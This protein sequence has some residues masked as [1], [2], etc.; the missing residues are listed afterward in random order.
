P[1]GNLNGVSGPSACGALGYA[2]A[3]SEYADVVVAVTDHLEEYPLVPVEI[4]QSRV[5]YVVKVDSIGDP[6][7]IVSGTTCVT[8]DP[9]GLKIAADT[10]KVMVASGLVKDGVSFQTGAG[11]ISLAVAQELE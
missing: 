7:G 11:G 1:F 10:L 2:V 6:S 4:R 5:D 8:R 9:I 3:D